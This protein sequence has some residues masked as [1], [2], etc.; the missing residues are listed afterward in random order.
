MKKLPGI[1]AGLAF[2]ALI[3]Q[4]LVVSAAPAAADDT[5]WVNSAFGG[6]SPMASGAEML[7]GTELESAT[8]RLAPLTLAFAVAGF[9]VAL[10]GVFW[11]V[12][13]PN[14]GG[15]GSCTGCTDAQINLQ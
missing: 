7:T 8:G 1:A 11:G 3:S 2:A 15:G 12:Y 14:Y 10:I 9:D 5:A 4:P 6:V 13:V